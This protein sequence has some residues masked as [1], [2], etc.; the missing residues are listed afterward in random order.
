MVPK[1][2]WTDKRSVHSKKKVSPLMLASCKGG[3]E[4]SLEELEISAEM[5]DNE[6]LLSIGINPTMFPSKLWHLVNDPQISSIYWDESGEG[7]LICKKTFKAEVL[8]TANKKMKKYFK[9]TDFISFLRQLNLYG[10]KKVYP[11]Y[12]ISMMQVGKIHHFYN[13]N[14]KRDNPE[15]M[16]NLTR[17]TPSNKAKLAAGLEVSKQPGRL[18]NSAVVGTVEH[19]ETHH[20]YS[21]RV[22][23]SDTTTKT[24]QAFVTG[25]DES[26]SEFSRFRMAF[27]WAYPSSPMQ[28]GSHCEVS[29]EY[30]CCIPPGSLDLN[31][32]C[33]QQEVAAYTRCG[34]YP[35]YSFSHLQYTDQ[36]PNWQA[37]VAPDPWK[38][39]MNLCAV[40]KVEDEVQ[41]YSLS[42]LQYTDQ[43]PTWQESVAPDPRKSYM[44]LE[45]VI[46][47]ED[48]VQDSSVSHLHCTGQAQNWQSADAPDP[49]KSHMNLG[50]V[51]RVE[52]EME[53]AAFITEL[54]NEKS[55][56]IADNCQS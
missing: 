45:T 27:P 37:G 8:F 44:N 10:F 50:T 5:D 13:P 28:Q 21:Q 54:S 16:V 51:F 36:N 22:K 18:K 9:T 48:K 38:S 31:M 6:V 29:D 25:H 12:E 49:R 55:P 56:G 7:I 26:S 24:F 17:L 2:L 15:L 30:Q 35:D 33:S 3:N 23:R 20:R 19:Q 41:D 47:V 39:Y 42:H 11:D 4:E 40:F 32:P 43:K 52:D 1:G 53:I 34:Y 14:F 46:V